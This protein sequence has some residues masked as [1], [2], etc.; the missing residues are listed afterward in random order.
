[1][2]LI[3][4]MLRD[5]EA[6]HVA[7]PRTL[8]PSNVR[9]LPI[10]PS[11]LALKML[12][13]SVLTA[14][15]FAAGLFSQRRFLPASHTPSV[16]DWFPT[17]GAAV[18]TSAAQLA[19]STPAP[20]LT[21]PA[22]TQAT[23]VMQVEAALP[24]ETA[25]AKITPMP[26]EVLVSTT[27]TIEVPREEKKP[28]LPK[29]NSAV[30]TISPAKF[31]IATTPAVEPAPILLA[32]ATNETAAVVIDKQVRPATAHERADE[33]YRKA[34]SALKQKQTE[35]ALIA[36]RNALQEDANHSAVR[37][38]LASILQQQQHYDEAQAVLQ[39]GLRL[40][41]AQAA[42]ATQL[43]RLQVERSDLAGAAATLQKHSMTGAG[44]P[45][46]RALHGVVLQRLGQHQH[47]IEEYQAALQLAPHAGV[48][49]MGLGFSLEAE[50][51]T[52]DARQAFVRA[53][54]S[55][56]LSVELDK[57][58]EQKLR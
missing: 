18:T 50:G 28:K 8:I 25:P 3:N 34:L 32:Q 46:Y 42:L 2:S 52:S 11:S 36:L 9:A 20:T 26:V 54:S 39:E 1:M 56:N 22:L 58:I 6:R 31:V 49:W 4:Q 40:N 57:F 7:E 55:G 43:A 45:D 38:T 13:L 23:P 30:E 44:N 14:L 47:A 12:V 19:S 24:S 33:G 51:K 10:K 37:Q 16:F 15:A 27:P 48:W 35:V 29:K 53:R 5:L 41:E 17:Q 21:S